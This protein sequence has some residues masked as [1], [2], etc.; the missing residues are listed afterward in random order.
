MVGE[1]R[2]KFILQNSLFVVICGSNDIANDF[3]A[4]PPVRLKY[5]VDSFTALMADNARSFALVMTVN[6]Y[7]NNK[8]YE[9]DY[10]IY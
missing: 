6:N 2:T 9:K 8:C 1:E 5:D 7:T 10:C 3:F 4:L